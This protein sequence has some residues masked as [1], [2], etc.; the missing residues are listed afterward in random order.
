MGDPAYRTQEH[1]EQVYRIL[2]E[3]DPEGRG[4]NDMLAPQ[5]ESCSWEDRKLVFRY[6]VQSWMQNPVGNMHGGAI[7]AA[8]DLTMGVLARYIKGSSASVTVHLAVEYVRGIPGDDEL[9][10]EA[11][12]E[13]N[14]KT[15]HF[16]T[17]K[18][19]RVSD[20]ELAAFSTGEF[21]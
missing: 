15:M 12:A 19:Y 4:M 18:A 11:Q 6:R 14:G 21:M 7:A 17:A 1:M 2:T 8:C 13:K 16:M 5:F 9:V 10:V 3:P 20:G